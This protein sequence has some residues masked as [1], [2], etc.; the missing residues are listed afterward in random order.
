MKIVLPVDGSE[1][2]KKTIAFLVT[3]ENMCGPD[4]ELIV[5]NVQPPMPPRVKSMVGATAVK[6]YHQE[7]AS[8]VLKPIERFLN[9]HKLNFRT[10]WSVGSAAQEVLRTVDQEQAHM[11]VMGTHG[12]GLLGRAIMGSVAQR[13]IADAHVPVLLVK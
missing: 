1:F 9:K 6:E 7:E 13:V 12:H 3:H 5:L 11:I 4:D 2:T 10:T 8:K